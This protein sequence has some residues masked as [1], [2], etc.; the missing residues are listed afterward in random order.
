MIEDEQDAE[1]QGNE[2]P[3][4]ELVEAGMVGGIVTTSIITR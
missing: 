3:Q 1:G 2:N 4:N